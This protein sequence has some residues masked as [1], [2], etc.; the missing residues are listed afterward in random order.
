MLRVLITFGFALFHKMTQSRV[1]FAY[2]PVS[3]SLICLLL[4]IPLIT[5]FF[6]S[7][8]LPGLVSLL[9][10]SPQSPGSNLISSIVLYTSVSRTQYHLFTNFSMV[11]LKALF[12][13]LFFSSCIPLLLKLYFLT[14]LQII[15]FMHVTRNFTCNF[16]QLALLITTLF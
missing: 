13:F 14:H 12:L 15:T 6:L 3:L 4:L 9:L 16:Q 11:F 2:L 1:W 5:L 7:V 10:L 8:S